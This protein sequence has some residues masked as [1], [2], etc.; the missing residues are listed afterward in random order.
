MSSSVDSVAASIR[1]G[2]FSYMQASAI[3]SLHRNGKV[4]TRRDQ[5]GSDAQWVGVDLAPIAMPVRDARALTGSDHRS[6]THNGF[7]LISEPYSAKAMNFMDN[8][9]V[10][11]DYYPHCAAVI[12]EMTGAAV[13]AAFDHNIRS[14]TGKNSKQRIK[15]GQQVQGPAHVVH[16]DYTLTSAPERLRKLAEP[17]RTNDTWRP[18]N[19]AASLLDPAQVEQAIRNG[20]FGII[21]LWRNIATEPVARNP[22]ALCDGQTVRP[23]DL[24][25][26]EIHYADRIGENYF[27]R[28]APGHQWY[29]Y[30]AMTPDEALLIT[31]WDSAGEL[32]K[33]NGSAADSTIPDSTC[34]FSFHSAFEDPTTPEDAPD[35]WSIEVRCAVLYV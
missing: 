33:S 29:C 30:P 20:R 4:L 1:Q 35:R 13:V 2:K 31:Q 24:V 14:A 15:G 11:S 3:P 22:M 5:D 17:P 12:R 28:H 9:Q 16:G 27:A 26:F 10:V 21:N 19:G 7:E 23:Q 6:L 18:P 8:D 25:V 32:A 34:T